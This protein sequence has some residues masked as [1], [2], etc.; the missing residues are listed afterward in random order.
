MI[1]GFVIWSLVALIF[2][3][4][5]IW[6]RNAKEAVGFFAGVRPPEVKDVKKY[7]HSVSGLWLVYAVLLEGLGVPFLFLEQ[8]SA[9]FV[10]PYLGVVV[11]TIGLIVAYNIILAKNQ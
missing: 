3:G 5:S 11:I 9:W 7:N 1:I 8:N 2:V 6:A 4:I 10:I